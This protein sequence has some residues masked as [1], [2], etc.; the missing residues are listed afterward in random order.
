VQLGDDVVVEETGLGGGN[1]PHSHRGEAIVQP[2]AK[3]LAGFEPNRDSK[4]ARDLAKIGVVR[5]RM[6]AH[7]FRSLPIALASVV[8]SNSASRSS[9]KWISQINQDWPRELFTQ[10]RP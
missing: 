10:P 5:C 4:G 6:L 7:A 9:A 3:V 2:L 1:L 8:P